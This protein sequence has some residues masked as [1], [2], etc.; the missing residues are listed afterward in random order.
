MKSPQKTQGTTLFDQ[1]E[2]GSIDRHLDQPYPPELYRYD[3][4]GKKIP[5]MEAIG[6]QEI[7]HFHE[8][9]WLAVE[10]AFT[11]KQMDAAEA[12]FTYLATGQHPS[13][14][15]FRFESAVRDRI[16]E[17]T[18]NEKM[19]AIRKLESFMEYEPRLR[20]IAYD[21]EFLRMLGLLTGSPGVTMFQDMALSK[22]P[23][24]GREKP[25]HQDC[26]YFNIPPDT[27][28]VGTWIALDD[29]D[30]KNGCMHVLDRGHQPGPQ[31]HFDRRDWQIC[32][33]NIE[34][35]HRSNH[36]VVAIP[37]RRGG[38]LFF[39]GLLPHGTP[40]NRSNRRRRALQYHYYPT[41]TVA[42]CED[43]RLAVF[44]GEGKGAEC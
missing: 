8:H 35:L 6:D 4:I 18:P 23:M 19:D 28:V 26:A 13:Y 15:G 41:T 22:P 42:T 17:L 38:C 2:G 39:K 27:P 11:Q 12:G 10:S 5:T 32:D 21:A 9:G 16:A 29:V 34:E 33:T 25:W 20:A 44:G 3:S 37:L 43:D 30:V 14:M 36:P 7:E 31:N 40:P 1:I 24:I